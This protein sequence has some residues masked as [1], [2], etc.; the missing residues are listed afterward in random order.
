M[1]R[2]ALIYNCKC[3]ITFVE[4]TE[5]VSCTLSTDEL[6]LL[7]FLDLMLDTAT[8]ILLV[9]TEMVALL[10]IGISDCNSTCTF[11]NTVLTGK[12]LSSCGLYLHM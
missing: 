11:S 3:I 10:D 1:N 7:S 9:V 2:H 6:G 8:A 4:V 5:S 12:H